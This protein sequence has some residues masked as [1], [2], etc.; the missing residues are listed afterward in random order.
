[1]RRGQ[2]HEPEPGRGALV[3]AFGVERQPLGNDLLCR[4]ASLDD[5]NRWLRRALERREQHK[6]RTDHFSASTQAPRHGLHA[7]QA[8]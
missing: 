8:G 4:L 2:G 3:V 5:R 1:M 7:S 6:D